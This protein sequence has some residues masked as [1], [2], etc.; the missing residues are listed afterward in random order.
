MLTLD[1]LLDRRPERHR[2]TRLLPDEFDELPV[3]R[4]CRG[5]AWRD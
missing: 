5:S 3:E 1:N 4:V 2:F